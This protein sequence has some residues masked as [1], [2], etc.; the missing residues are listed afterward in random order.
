[1]WAI[2]LKNAAGTSA[3]VMATVGTGAAGVTL[4]GKFADAIAGA[5]T[6]ANAA[7]AGVAADQLDVVNTVGLVSVGDIINATGPLWTDYVAP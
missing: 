1:M 3:T 4:D 5:A 2:I 6:G 7:G